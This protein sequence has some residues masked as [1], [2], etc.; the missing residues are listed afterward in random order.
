M[1]CC[2]P[3]ELQYNQC[4]DFDDLIMN[5][6]RLFEEHPDSLTYYQ[7]K[8]HYIHVDE[9]QDTNHAQ[10]T[11]V[12]L[13][14]GRFRN[15]CV[16]G[17][18][19]QSIYGWRGADM[20]NILDFEK[21]YPDAAVI[22]LE[23][24]YRSTKNILSAANQVIENNSNRKPKNLWTENKEGNK[25]TYYRADN[26]RDE[27]RFIVDRMQEEIRS[28]HRN[29]GDFAILYRTNAQSR[30]MEE[31]L[32]KANI[33]YKM[34]G[35]HKFYDRKEIKDILA[36]LNVLANPQDS[37]SFE[38][39]VNS[40]KRGIGPGS[41][42]KLRSFASLHEWPLLEAAQ[43]VDLAN[44]GGK[45]GQQLGAFGEMIQE[46]TQMIQYLTVT[47][48][49]KEVL[50]RSGYLEDLKIQNTLEAQARIE[51]LEEFLTVTQE[52]DKQFEQQNEE[53]ADAPE[54]KL[55]VFLNDLA[56]VSD[57]DNLEEDASQ[58]TLMTLHAAK[59]LEFPVV[60]LI[61]LEEGFF[62]YLEH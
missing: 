44:I 22:L 43:N 11:L 29:Y 5:T 7:N 30:V 59:G 58:V 17:D 36:Y 28:N 62:L 61:G 41:I 50:D 4:M 24:N 55:T 38:R 6:I 60:F 20:Q 47:E 25:I 27:T 15:L 40:P 33:P 49:T 23:Q 51:N 19:D 14:A 37:I 2:L 13:L 56:L 12:N 31:T 35:G 8:F 10:Y 3:K 18:A 46:V 54:E 9:Y 57:I 53:D 32:L 45:A 52:F 21:D 48:L 1:L 42:E 26:E 16:V 39:I 34:V